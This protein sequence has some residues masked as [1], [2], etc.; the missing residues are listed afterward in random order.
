MNAQRARH[1]RL[2]TTGL[3]AIVLLAGAGGLAVSAAHRDRQP[4]TSPVP[5]AGLQTGPA[6]WSANTAGLA[7]RLQAVGLAPL[8]PMEGTAVHIHQHLDL[9]VDGHKVP[10]PASVGI[11][12]AVGYARCTPTTPAASSTSSRPLCAPTP[13]GSSS[14]CGVSG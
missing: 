10:V 5:L 11:N 13:S 12:P 7:E 3:L 14:P 2:G 6:P 4:A 8:I 9:D 1:R